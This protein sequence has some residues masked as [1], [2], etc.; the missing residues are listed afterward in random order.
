MCDLRTH[1]PACVQ[2]RLIWDFE[3]PVP[4]TVSR[5]PCCNISFRALSQGTHN[6]ANLAKIMVRIGGVCLITIGIW[7][8]IEMA[9]QFGHYKHHCSLGEGTLP[10]LLAPSL[11]ARVAALACDCVLQH[12]ARHSLDS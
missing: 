9:V 11:Y 8:I 1:A 3:K 2:L 5:L 7:C 4:V 12:N 6:Q 10:A